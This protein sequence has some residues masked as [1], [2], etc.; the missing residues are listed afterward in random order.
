MSC[1]EGGR[2]EPLKQPKKQAQ[3]MDEKDKALRQK[4]KE[5]QKKMEEL[6]VKA[7]GKGSPATGGIKK[8]GKK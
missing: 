2:K 8:S 3:G 6:K 4:Q 1:R 5:E 7:V